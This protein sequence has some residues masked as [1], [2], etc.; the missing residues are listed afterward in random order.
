MPRVQAHPGSQPET[1]VV[2]LQLMFGLRKE[3]AD[4]VLAMKFVK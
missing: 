4:L 2:E 3:A 1:Q